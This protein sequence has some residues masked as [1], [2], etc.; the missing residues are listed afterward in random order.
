MTASDGVLPRHDHDQS[1]DERQDAGQ[2]QA[3]TPGQLQASR[4]ASISSM[5]PRTTAQ[6]PIR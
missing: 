5:R 3:H 1:E 2:A 6:P 4:M